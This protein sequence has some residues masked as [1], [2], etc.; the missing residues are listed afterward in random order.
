[1]FV[2]LLALLL[3]G[4]RRARGPSPTSY[5]GFD[6]PGAVWPV[7][8]YVVDGV[9]YRATVSSGMDSQRNNPDGSK[10]PHR[11]LD[12]MFKRRTRADRPEHPAG[13]RETDGYTSSPGYFAPPGTP[14]LAAREG[15]VWSVKL[16]SDGGGISVVIDHGKP[17]ATYYT[18][19]DTVDV[20]PGDVVAAGQRIGTMGGNLSDGARIR[21]LHFEL[22]Y[23]GSGSDASVDAWAD[24][25]MDAWSRVTWE[26][27]ATVN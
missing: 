16:R 3:G 2:L 22:W 4:N 23:Q 18:H 25:A 17:W 1:M 5:A 8:S 24:K 12:I 6:G 26:P 15:R 19:L 7:P 20:K 13:K 11:G 27:T 14:I 21:H 9:T 10:R